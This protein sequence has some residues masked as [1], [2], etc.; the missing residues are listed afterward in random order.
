MVPQIGSAMFS[1]LA[2]TMFFPP[3]RS[4]VAGSVDG[5]FDFI[6]Y[7]SLFFFVL[8]VGFMVYFVMK[9]YQRPGHTEM[10]S[11]SHNET[12]EITWSVIP[13]IL[14]GVI[15]FF[16][17]T[18]YLNLREAPENAY[19]IQV[20]ASKWNWVFKYPNGAESS[21]LHIPVDRDVK[22]LLQSQDVLHSFY[23]PAF[24]IKM[25]CVPGRYTSTWARA[26][27][28]TGSGLDE[29]SH[30]T[31]RL[32][33][34][35][36]CGQQHS[37]M[38]RKVFVHETAEFELWAEKAA[39]ILENNPLDV[40]GEIL[41]KRK[42]CAQ[43]HS[44]DGDNSAKYPGPPLNGQ[45]GTDRQVLPRGSSSPVTV[46]MDENY[47]RQS[48]RQPNSEIVVGRKPGMT[49]FTPQLLKD[50]EITAIIAYLKTLK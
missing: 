34:A 33:C 4:T 26:T 48:I 38:H 15:F 45:W 39:N 27:Q 23:I 9:Y 40:A 49:V 13:S 37:L 20:I 30:K 47:V 19:E 7:L 14:V 28:T 6:Y 16:G 21:D 50:E 25:D 17:F 35:E 5:L 10:P 46:T 42:G 18:G 31:L 1:I 29:S 22:F 36:Y 41:F 24:R 44:V 43:C 12:L 32:F 3:E 11:P 8:I 2:D